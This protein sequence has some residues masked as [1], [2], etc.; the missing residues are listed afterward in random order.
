MKTLLRNTGINAFALFLLPIIVPG[1]V[2]EGGLL[3]L[4]FGGLLLTL[5][6]FVIKPLLDILSFPLNLVTMGL[7]SIVT[8]AI[9]LYLLTIFVSGIIIR[10]FTYPASTFFG[11]STPEVALSTLLVFLAAAGVLAFIVTG[12]KWLIE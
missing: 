3:T 12:I 5:L 7:F 10:P 8:N 6:L 9:I 4:L 1:V 11:F 2:I